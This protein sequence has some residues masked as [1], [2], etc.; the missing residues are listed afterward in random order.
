MKSICKKI[1]GMSVTFRDESNELSSIMIDHSDATVTTHNHS[2]I[3]RS[4]VLLAT[5]HATVS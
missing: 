4:N 1:S 5:I 3:M 2:I